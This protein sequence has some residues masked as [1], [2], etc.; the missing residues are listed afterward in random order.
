MIRLSSEQ[1]VY[2]TLEPNYRL[3]TDREKAPSAQPLSQ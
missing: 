1:T 2:S 3:E